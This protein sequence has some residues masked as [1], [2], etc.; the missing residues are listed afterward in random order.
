MKM[1]D[2]AIVG[3]ACNFPGGK[4]VESFWHTLLSGHDAITR[5]PPARWNA[6]AYFN[7]TGR[8]KQ[9]MTM[10]SDQGG[11]V[12]GIDKFDADFF[13]ISESEALFL[14]PQQRM[15]MECGW[16]ALEHAG[17][18]PSTLQG[19]STGVYVGSCNHDY[20]ILSWPESDDIYIGTGTSNALAANRLSYLLKV[21]GPSLSIDTACSSSLT[22]LHLACTSI[23]A[24]EIDCALVGGSNL[25]LLPSVNCSLSKAGL[26]SSSGRCN[27]FGE[28]ARGYIRSEG[29]GLIVIMPVA[30]AKR[31]GLR[32]ICTIKASGINHNGASNGLMAPS[33]P[34][35][36]ALLESVYQRAGLDHHQVRYVEAAA[37]GTQM[38]DVIE[39]KAIQ[40]FFAPGRDESHGPLRVGSLKSNVGHMEGAG[41]VAGVIKAALIA[42]RG[43]VPASLHSQTLNPL[44]NLANNVTIPQSNEPLLREQNKATVRDQDDQPEVLVSVSSFGFGGSN[45]HVVIGQY[46]PPEAVARD[47]APLTVDEYKYAEAEHQTRYPILVS[48]KTPA[49]LRETALGLI[50][51][52]DRN[53]DAS[54][55]DIAISCARHKQ[56]FKHRLGCFARDTKALKEQLQSSLDSLLNIR[57]VN[58]SASLLVAYSHE[59][60]AEWLTLVAK[61]DLFKL[62]VKAELNEVVQQYGYDLDNLLEKDVAAEAMSDQSRG[63]IFLLDYLLLCF[64]VKLL[65]NVRR[66]FVTPDKLILILV[67]TGKLNLQQGLSLYLQ[68]EPDSQSNSAAVSSH[69]SIVEQ[70]LSKL[71]KNIQV[72]FGE[73][74]SHNSAT[75]LLQ[76]EINTKPNE[77]LIGI[78]P[79][80]TA[81]SPECDI[82][83]Y[84]REVSGVSEL[85]MEAYLKQVELDL[86]VLFENHHY[87][88]LELPT[89]SFQR[90]RFWPTHDGFNRHKQPARLGRLIDCLD[91]KVMTQPYKG[92]HWFEYSLSVSDSRLLADYVILDF[93]IMAASTQIVLV[94][95][96][97]RK[98]VLPQKSGPAIRISAHD[99]V[100][101]NALLLDHSQVVAAR[102]LLDNDV[103]ATEAEASSTP[104]Y[105]AGIFKLS[106]QRGEYWD[107]HLEGR[108]QAETDTSPRDYEPLCFA[109]ASNLVEGAEIDDFYNK[110]KH[111]GYAFG[112][113]H[114][115]LNSIRVD[116]NWAEGVVQAEREAHFYLSPMS[117]GLVDTAFHLLEFLAQYGNQSALEEQNSTTIALPVSVS[118]IHFNYDHMESASHKIQVNLRRYDA[119]ERE[120]D[121]YILDENNCLQIS[122]TSVLFR[123]VDRVSLAAHWRGI[124]DTSSASDGESQVVHESG[125]SDASVEARIVTDL[126]RTLGT[127]I[128]EAEMSLPLRKLGVDSLKSIE[129]MQLVQ[130]RFG[131][132]LSLQDLMTGLTLR[133]L[134]STVM[135]ELT[136][137]E[138]F[139]VS[140][141]N[142]IDTQ[143]DEETFDVME[144][145]ENDEVIMEFE[146]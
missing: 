84:A 27:S 24:G 70:Q 94:A 29:A 19:S 40:D 61:D 102:L 144:I 119:T 22:A 78:G 92:V 110:L 57:S 114:R 141:E 77:L 96:Q 62:C 44:I 28:Q 64:L 53:S 72:V 65:P 21:N 51:W 45:G 142:Q 113:H 121:I 42:S 30:K 82:Q 17:I 132:K 130:T 3:I 11:F 115:W 43:V 99:L 7:Q 107:G 95:T 85:L 87:S 146:L 34:A 90:Q 104:H 120:A 5:V 54:I 66:Y 48:A 37:T 117:P 32:I 79:L 69:C 112:P 52:L 8:D 131:Y 124:S 58:Q 23:R 143:A 41:G 33:P 71:P 140:P 76:K 4:G 25:L 20:S 10:V 14:D 133:Q 135:A 127:E 46:Q 111:K 13:G 129:I 56:H 93:S 123:C 12:E 9:P 86:R 139:L 36:K 125:L 18:V 15:L 145:V 81:H 108:W 49:A 109:K 55:K 106:S 31:E 80:A 50:D 75:Q 2:I 26:L 118:E 122:M 101:P 100:L 138:G 74:Q 68:A 97:L 137:R 6:E 38:G 59:S 16:E 128:T 134:V 103:A 126:S 35:Q 91:A 1:D 88:F 67:A 105:T 63:K 47:D 98:M 83:F 73:E 60:A 89:Y 116:D 39:M 136:T